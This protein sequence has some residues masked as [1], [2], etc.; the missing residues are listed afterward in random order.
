MANQAD[1]RRIAKA[2]PA[3]EEKRE[4]F[5]FCVRN[6]G[7]LKEFAWVWKERVD[8]GK[9]RVPNFDVIAVRVPALADRERL[10]AAHPRKFFTE[11]HYDGFPAVLVRVKAVTVAELR[12]LLREAWQCQAPADLRTRLA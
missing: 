1:V 4:R 7:K 11:P 5:A 9:P 8:S 6:K 12:T 2:L 3:V 10:I